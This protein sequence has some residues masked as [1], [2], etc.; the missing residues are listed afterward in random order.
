[1]DELFGESLRCLVVLFLY[2]KVF[3]NGGGGGWGFPAFREVFRDVLRVFW[4]WSGVFPAWST[5]TRG[6]IHS[7]KIQ[8][9]P[10]GKRGPPQKVDQFFRSFSG[11]TEPIH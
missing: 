4:G 10:T 6:A 7:T 5:D 2:F 8:T 9:G 11:W 1:M 3:G